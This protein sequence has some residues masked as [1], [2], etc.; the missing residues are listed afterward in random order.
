[1]IYSLYSYLILF[2]PYHV[3]PDAYLL[4]VPAVPS[5][6]ERSEGKIE[7]IKTTIQKDT[8]LSC[9]Q[10]GVKP[11]PTALNLTRLPIENTIPLLESVPVIDAKAQR[12]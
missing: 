3:R 9:G 10:S 12:D 8:L 4:P 6:P 7:D 11:T 5:P 2:S 1:M